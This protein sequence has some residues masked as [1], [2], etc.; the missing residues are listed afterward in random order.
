MQGVLQSDQQAL[1][2]S[3]RESGIH[4]N[5]VHVVV[6]ETRGTHGVLFRHEDGQVVVED[7]LVRCEGMMVG[8]SM[9]D[10]LYAVRTQHAEEAARIADASNSVHTTA[11]EVAEGLRYV[12]CSVRRLN[13]RAREPRRVECLRRR[14]FTSLR[15]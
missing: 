10:D 5:E 15:R 2:I 11:G 4:G 14:R 7:K 13:K 8:E 6:R 1:R 9:L 3:L 12:G